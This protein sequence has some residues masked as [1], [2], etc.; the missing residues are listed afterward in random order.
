MLDMELIRTRYLHW[1]N[2]LYDLKGYLHWGLNMYQH[3][4]G[5]VWTGACHPQKGQGGIAPVEASAQDNIN[6]D[7]LPAGDTHI[8]Y[9]MGQKILTSVRFEMM[10]A[11]CEDYELLA[12]LKKKDA[13]GA[14]AILSSCVRS[15]TDYTGELDVFDKAYARLLGA[16]E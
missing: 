13:K 5:G 4:P 10:R 1:A 7:T 11:G 9:P 12:L 16:L 8:L 2:L 14:E 15:C 3:S 6:N